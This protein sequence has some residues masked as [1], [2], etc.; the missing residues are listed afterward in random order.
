MTITF[1]CA[2]RKRE[3]EVH[4]RIMQDL[5]GWLE[6]GSVEGPPICAFRFDSFLDAIGTVSTRHALGEVMAEMS[7]R[8][9]RG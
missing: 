9:I 3:P 8:H 1:V 6:A 4:D 5:L 7:D 2:L